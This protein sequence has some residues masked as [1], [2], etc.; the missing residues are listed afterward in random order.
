MDAVTKMRNEVKKYI[1]AADEK[2]VKMVHAMLEVDAD[3]GWWNTLPDDVKQDVE[4]SLRQGDGGEV[5][6]H[7][8]VKAKYRQW[9]TK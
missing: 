3:A 5:L 2:T 6:T 1:D 9:F 8:Q 4:Q 7:E